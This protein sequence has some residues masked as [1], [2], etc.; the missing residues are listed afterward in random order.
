MIRSFA[1][2]ETEK[3]GMVSAAASGLRLYKTAR[4]LS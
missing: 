2:P 4:F 3:S 1:D